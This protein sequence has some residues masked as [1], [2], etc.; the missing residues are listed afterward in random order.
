MTKIR[1]L[2]GL[3]HLGLVLDLCDHALVYVLEVKVKGGLVAIQFRVAG[4]ICVVGIY[5][6]ILK[7]CTTR[8]IFDG[9][10]RAWEDFQVLQVD[11]LNVRRLEDLHLHPVRGA[12]HLVGDA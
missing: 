1:L 6:Q 11:G 9:N 8:M 3:A 10:V 4:F 7:S 12:V 5:K 2:Y